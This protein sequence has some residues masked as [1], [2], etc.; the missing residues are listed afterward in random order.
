VINGGATK[1]YD[2]ICTP[3]GLSAIAIKTNGARSLYYVQTDHLGSIR[4]VTTASKAIQ[5]RYCYDAWGKQTLMSGTGITSRGYL[6]QEHLNEFELITLNARLYDPVLARFLGIDPYVQAPDFTQS[7]NRYAYG[8]NNPFKYTDPEGENP[9]LIA[10]IIIGV[11]AGGYTGYKIADAKG[12]D[13]G[14]WQTYAY[15][16][17]GA[18]I[19]GA[20]GY[21][22]ATVALGGGFMANTMGIMYGSFFNSMGMTALSGG[23]LSPSV[24]FGAASYDLGTGEWGYLGKKG[25]KWYQDV[26]YGL[27][28]LANVSDILNGFQPQ[29]VDLVTEHSDAVGHSAIVEEG[30]KAGG[31]DGLIS[32]GPDWN[33]APENSTWHWTKGTNAWKSYS[34]GTKA[35]PIWRQTLNVNIGTIDKYGQWL[36]KM[37]SAGKLVYSVELSSCV[38]HTSVALNLSG[39]F[40]IGIHPYLL[41]AQ[42]YLWS[43][44]LRPWTFNYLLNQ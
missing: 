19:G 32:V 39:V 35:H 11:V 6:A 20:S 17:G 23:M 38:T 30:S 40:N 2:Y 28:A 37:E 26:G 22:G 3:E 31:S 7:Y 16:L 1:E 25:N 41:N 21:L 27:G 36:N 14:N 13:F 34:D 24:S 44:G 4:I 43:N 42:M 9:V 5:T 10:A 8:L 29:N 15:M 33:S 12:Y 18:A